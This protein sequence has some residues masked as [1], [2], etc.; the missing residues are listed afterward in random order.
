MS[1]DE[2][3][4][5][6]GGLNGETPLG[7]IVSIRSEKDPERLKQFTAAEKKIRNEWIMKHRRVVTDKKEY[8]KAMAEFHSMFKALS[9]KGG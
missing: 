6:L 7:H 4:T 5:L 3:T 1:W 9:V 2:F 8:D